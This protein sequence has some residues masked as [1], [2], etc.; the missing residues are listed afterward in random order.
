MSIKEQ[1][2]KPTEVEALITENERLTNEIKR[3]SNKIAFLSEPPTDIKDQ[4][5]T[6]QLRF[7]EGYLTAHEANH[8][9]N[10]LPLEISFID[11]NDIFK[12]FNE[13]LEPSE[14]MFV[15]TSDMI[16]DDVGRSHPSKSHGKV[17]PLVRDLKSGKRHIESMWFKK[18]DQYVY[19]SFKAIF[20]EN[21][22]YLGIM[23]Y[24]QD[25]QPFFELPTEMK[26]GLGNQ[27]EGK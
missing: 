9:L 15:R 2:I 6:K 12:Y 24:V 26:V 16:G 20:D 25:I 4:M 13:E 21:G 14:M 7:G 22:E 19:V 10:N 17:M 11:K 23:E 8:L 1:K 18:K 27:E 3:L 5:Y